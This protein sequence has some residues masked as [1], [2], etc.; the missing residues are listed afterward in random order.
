MSRAVL[1]AVFAAACLPAVAAQ[2]TPAQVED[3]Y[4]PLA[5]P[6]P[7]ER[8]HP[9]SF[10]IWPGKAAA[11]PSAAPPS[12]EPNAAPSA[13]VSTPAPLASPRRTARTDLP[14][15][16]YGPPPARVES[17]AERAPPPA[18]PSQAQAT[19]QAPQP[20]WRSQSPYATAD[21]A[22]PRRYSV[23]REFGVKPDPAPLPQQFFGPSVDL[24]DPPPLPPPKLVSGQTAN[25][26]A[27]QAR[28]DAETPVAGDLNNSTGGD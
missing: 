18:P 16:L 14:T 8:P 6:P 21:G 24:A 7:A 25:N 12:T 10:L 11:P 4:G 19:P 2:A 17:A 22:P 9:T 28:A 3:R 15:S 1:F 20:S 23:A 26:P 27:N 13:A 5:P